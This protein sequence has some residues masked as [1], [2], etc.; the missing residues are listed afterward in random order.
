MMRDGMFS[1]KI[2]VGKNSNPPEIPAIPGYVIG[3]R[4]RNNTDPNFGL[5][6]TLTSLQEQISTTGREYGKPDLQPLCV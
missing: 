6:C 2:P 4:L 5:Q 1:H 3:I